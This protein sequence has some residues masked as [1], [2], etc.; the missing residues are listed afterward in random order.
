MKQRQAS[1]F[2]CFDD[3]DNDIVLVTHDHR[4]HMDLPT[5]EQARRRAALHRAAR[6]RRR[7]SK[8][9]PNVVELD[10]WQTHEVGGARD[11]A[12]AR[13]PLVDARAVEQERH[14]VGRLRRSAAPE[15]IAYHSG[16]TACGDHFAEIGAARRHDRLGD[17]AD[18]RL[19]AALVH[20]A[21]ARR[22]DR[23]GARLRGAR[24]DATCSRCTGARFGSPTRR[25]ASRRSGCARTGTSTGSTGATVDPRRRRSAPAPAVRLR[26][27]G[28]SPTR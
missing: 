27:R 26:P 23:G 16:D 2:D 3:V 4:D 24:R 15:G 25:S 20:G 17:A 6:Q 12:R 28:R 19:L 18:R 13:A 8:L 14:A 22:S 21:A 9:G 1:E 11:H 10:W 5:L 7:G